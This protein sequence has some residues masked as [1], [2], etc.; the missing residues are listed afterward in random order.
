VFT[1]APFTR[2]RAKVG[3]AILPVSKSENVTAG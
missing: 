1:D 2:P 3:L